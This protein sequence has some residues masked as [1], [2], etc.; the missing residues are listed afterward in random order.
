MDT[1]LPTSS[2][3]RG[4]FAPSPTGELHWGSLFNA[5]ASF[6]Q[7][8]SQHGEW[9]LRIDDLDQA[10]CQQLF[11]DSILFTLERFGLHWDGTVHYQSQQED[12]YLSALDALDKHQYLYACSCSRKQL[13]RY[14]HLHPETPDYPGFCRTKTID[15]DQ[16][17]SKRVITQPTPIQLND[18]L[19]GNFQE[20]L[21]ETC[22]DF[23]V[24]RSDKVMSYHLASVVDDFNMGINQIVRGYDL[25][26]SSMQQC[27]LQQLLEYPTPQHIHLPLIVD[28]T[29]T[30]LSK[31]TGAAPITNYD[32]S[33]TL[34]LMLKQLKQNPPSSLHRES[35]NAIISWAID[36]WNIEKLKNCKTILLTDKHHI[37][38]QP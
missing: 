33:E 24:Y 4:R 17:H 32:V 14:H 16:Q 25:L 12:Y 31:Q 30:K 26:Q 11:A 37:D 1:P 10:R 22:G 28:S 23:I 18:S 2:F 34:F 9:R 19:Q 36:H 21:S 29:A 13:K 3:Y 7:T 20:V 15:Q 5:L 27:Y 38:V 6:L 8:R 35:P